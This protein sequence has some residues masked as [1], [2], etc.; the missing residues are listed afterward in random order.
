MWCA[1]LLVVSHMCT[2]GDGFVPTTVMLRKKIPF[3]TFMANGQDR[4]HVL[5]IGASTTFRTRSSTS[6]SSLAMS[7]FSADGSEYSSKESDY[8]F[9]EMD[10]NSFRNMGDSGIV[11]DD[12]PTEELQP[13]PMSKNAGNRFVASYWDHELQK[14]DPNDNRDPW[15]LH[16][17]RDILNEDH[18]MFCRKRN[19][20]NETFNSD[21]MVD[22]VRS[23]PM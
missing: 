21:S 11:E 9:E 15:E 7:S 14:G 5:Q 18:V 3:T 13:V 1:L 2:V 16:Y 4:T 17:D 20:Y 22:V 8:D 12:F 6:F 10:M 19:L 23:F